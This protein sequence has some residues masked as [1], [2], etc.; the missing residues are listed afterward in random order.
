MSSSG[1]VTMSTY[2]VLT[3]PRKA[4]PRTTV[5]DS[6]I[7][8]SG[9]DVLGSIR[10]YSE[11]ERAYPDI[12]MYHVIAAIAKMEKG[13]NVFTEDPA[14]QAEYSFVGDIK[15]LGLI[16]DDPTSALFRSI[17]LGI[18]CPYIFASGAVT[19]SDNNAGTFTLDPEQWTNAFNDHA[20]VQATESS[21]APPLKSVFPVIGFFPETARYKKKPVPWVKQYVS[22]GG[23]LSGIASSLEGETMQERF[24]VE[25]DNI[26][27]LGVYTPLAS[28]PSPALTASTSGASGSSAGSKKARFSYS[29][30]NQKRRRDDDSSDGPS[31]SPSPATATNSFSR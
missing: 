7:H 30:F 14:E 6:T 13:I 29:S 17:D 31:S 15:T 16:S 21:A 1:L 2:T 26:A 22:F 28:T 9:Q 27:F 20:K 12:G 11:A 8:I 18:L 19:R 3:N 4:S 23:Y 25:V 10:Y 24:R 5:F